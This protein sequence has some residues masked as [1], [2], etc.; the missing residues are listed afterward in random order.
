VEIVE[1]IDAINKLD[2]DQT[3]SACK[4]V[5]DYIIDK[6]NLSE[7][8]PDSFSF[9]RKIFDESESEVTNE[10][11]RDLLENATYSSVSKCSNEFL[12]MITKELKD[13]DILDILDEELINPPS[14]ESAHLEPVS[15]TVLV[16][17]AIAFLVLT[18]SK[19]KINGYSFDGTKAAN[20]STKIIKEIARLYKSLK[21]NNN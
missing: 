19:F 9:F 13:P 14:E 4:L 3:L 8:I 5:A 21:K 2:S 12:K 17:G 16:M 10:E 18:G 7:N 15:I 6:E 11:I 1:R 20:N